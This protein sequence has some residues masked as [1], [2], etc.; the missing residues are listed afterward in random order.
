[1]RFKKSLKVISVIFLLVV[2]AFVGLIQRDL[3]R[4]HEIVRERIAANGTPAPRNVELAFDIAFP[5]ES[6]HFTYLGYLYAHNFSYKNEQI[7]TMTTRMIAFPLR[8]D[9]A[10]LLEL[11]YQV[12][13]VS[14]SEKI[15]FVYKEAGTKV[16]GSFE[17]LALQKFKKAAPELSVCQSLVLLYAV[18]DQVADQ[19][20][21][22]KCKDASSDNT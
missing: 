3:N 13:N 15:N 21:L 16:Y 6:P 2:A 7:N 11:D 8:T 14:R 10:R 1:M 18:L 22:A 5:E 19:E 4:G 12:H 17:Q 20:K 9:F